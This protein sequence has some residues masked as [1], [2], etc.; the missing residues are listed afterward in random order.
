MG[1]GVVTGVAARVDINLLERQTQLHQSLLVQT[2]ARHRQIEQLADGGALGLLVGFRTAQHV[3]G[4]DASLPVGRTRQRDQHR[5]A[6]DEIGLLHRIPHRKDEGIRGTHAGIDLDA[7]AR[8]Q[9]QPRLGGEQGFGLDADGED[10][11]TGVEMGAVIEGQTQAA[12]VGGGHGC[13]LLGG[14]IQTLDG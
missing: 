6:G 3:V 7:A 14:Q 4:G 13:R 9:F 2:G 12:A 11:H 8:P 10:Q 1:T 5:F